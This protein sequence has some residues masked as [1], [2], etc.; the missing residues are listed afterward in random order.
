VKPGLPPR[1]FIARIDQTLKTGSQDPY[2]G[3]QVFYWGDRSE[4]RSVAWSHHGKASGDWKG[5][6]DLERDRP[7]ADGR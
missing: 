4:R 6:V 5:K 3:G 1:K 2:W 7:I